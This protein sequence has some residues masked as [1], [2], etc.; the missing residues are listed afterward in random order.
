[1]EHPWRVVALIV[2]LELDDALRVEEVPAGGCNHVE[3]EPAQPRFETYVLRSS[4]G[5]PR[6]QQVCLVVAGEGAVAGAHHLAGRGRFDFTAMQS[7]ATLG[8]TCATAGA[9]R[10]SNGGGDVGRG[11]DLSLAGGLQ[12]RGPASV[13]IVLPGVRR[14][15]RCVATDEHT[16]QYTVLT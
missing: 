3:P 16:P 7:S 14:S 12:S 10:R 1:M 4:V 5:M 15:A 2:G 13:Q 9:T 6:S 11:H 8:V